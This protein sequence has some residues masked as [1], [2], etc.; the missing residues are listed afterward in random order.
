MKHM[1]TLAIVAVVVAVRGLLVARVEIAAISCCC[2]VVGGGSLTQKDA[3]SFSILL[4]HVN[5]ETS[6]QKYDGENGR[7]GQK[8]DGCI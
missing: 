1:L 5:D 7:S 4:P 2:V 8:N 6:C 3:E